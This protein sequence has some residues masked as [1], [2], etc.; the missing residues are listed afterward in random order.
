M[1][2]LGKSPT[3]LSQDSNV[4]AASLELDGFKC[5]MLPQVCMCSYRTYLKISNLLRLYT[6]M[7]ILDE[8]PLLS[9]RHTLSQTFSFLL[10]LC[11]LLQA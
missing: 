7:F 1:D 6:D 8:V 9:A 10:L 11:C 4:S 3:N 2:C 5:S